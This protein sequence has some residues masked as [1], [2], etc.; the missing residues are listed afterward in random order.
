[1]VYLGLLLINIAI[2]GLIMFVE[3]MRIPAWKLDIVVVLKTFAKVFI[4]VTVFIWLLTW[5]VRLMVE[6]YANTL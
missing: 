5:G 2:S 6:Y 3:L 4:A 1:M